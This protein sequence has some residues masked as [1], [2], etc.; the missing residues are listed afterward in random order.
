MHAQMDTVERSFVVAAMT[1]F[2]VL[3]VGLSWLA[4]L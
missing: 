2:L 4:C 1:G 3:V